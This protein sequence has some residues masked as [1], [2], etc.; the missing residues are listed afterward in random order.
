MPGCV[1]GSSL[2]ASSVVFPA[3]ELLVSLNQQNVILVFR[4]SSRH[5][6]DDEDRFCTQ[7]GGGMDQPGGMLHGALWKRACYC[8]VAG[9]TA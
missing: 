9:T 8:F 2:S 6:I 4:P 3:E 1:L 7:K 5:H